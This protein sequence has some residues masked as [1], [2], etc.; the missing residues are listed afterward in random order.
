LLRT[1]RNS[2]NSS[3]RGTEKGF[4]KIL[5]RAK[6]YLLLKRERKQRYLMRLS[7]KKKNLSRRDM[8]M[9]EDILRQRRKSITLE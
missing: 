2:K 4:K 9:L 7:V 5:R 8:G 6:M 3:H 1:S